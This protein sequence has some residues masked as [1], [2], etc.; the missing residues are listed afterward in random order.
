MVKSSSKLFLY[1]LISALLLFGLI[2]IILSSGLRF[3]PPGLFALFF[4]LALSF[5]GLL[6]YSQNGERKLFLFYSL[7]L[8]G[9]VFAWF[10]SGNFHLVLFLLALTGFL[11]SLPQKRGCCQ[12]ISSSPDLSELG[13]ANLDAAVEKDLSHSLVFSAD[14]DKLFAEEETEKAEKV[15]AKHVPG[16]YI[17]ST[18]GNVYHEPR[19]A[20]AKKINKDRQLWFTD[21]NKARNQGY[22]AHNCVN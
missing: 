3:F 21:K 19:C 13:D 10:L 1:S 16:K 20:W 14:E 11:M 8:A 5:L 2:K 15:T 6:K 4:L 12:K 7:Y 18:Q 22:K 17:A 9:L